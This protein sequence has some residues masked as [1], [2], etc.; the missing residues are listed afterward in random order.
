MY[1][2][3]ILYILPLCES[4]TFVYLPLVLYNYLVGREGQSW[5]MK[6]MLRNVDF[7]LRMRKYEVEFYRAHKPLGELVNRK[8]LWNLNSRHNDSFGLLALLPCKEAIPKMKDVSKWI[9]ANFPEFEGGKRY[10]IYKINPYL[11]W[12]LYRYVRPKWRSFLRIIKSFS[13]KS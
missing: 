2:D 13:R 6:V 11:F 4:K 5:D 10:A 9:D 12:I 1:D 3:E 8:L 7:K